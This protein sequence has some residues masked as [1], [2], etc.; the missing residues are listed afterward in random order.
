MCAHTTTFL[1][2]TSSLTHYNNFPCR[3]AEVTLETCAY[4]GTGNVLKV[5]SM[6]RRC[7]DHLTENA[8]HQAVAVL[9]IALTNIGRC[10]ELFDVVVVLS[11]GLV[12]FR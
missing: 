12:D 2:L 7:T 5:Q 1:C 3:Y 6:L 8:E 10:F 11:H 4:A 9:G